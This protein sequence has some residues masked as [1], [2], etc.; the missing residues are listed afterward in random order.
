MVEELNDDCQLH[1]I[2]YL[3]LPDQL[4]L[5]RATKNAS[6]RWNNNIC[7]AWR[8]QVCYSL[9]S[10]VFEEFDNDPA[11]LDAFL[12]SICNT[13][14]SVEFKYVTL[15]HLKRWC[16]YKF[17]NMRD[18]KYTLDDDERSFQT[19]LELLVEMFPA[20]KSLKPYGDINC[21]KIEQFK[22]LR[23]LDL[24]ECKIYDLEGSENLEELVLEL[25]FIEDIFQSDD[26]MS[27]PRLQT[28]SYQCRAEYEKLLVKA[29]K[30]RC[31]D[32][33]ELSF[34]DCIWAYDLTT[35]QSP[36]CLS[37][38]SLIED[39]GLQ[40]EQ[41]QTLVA[42]LPLL[43]QLDLVDFQFYS[44]E[45]QLWKTVAVCPS[46]EILN[47]SG[48]QLYEDFFVLNRR[49]MDQALRNRSVPL[50]LHCHNTGANG[51]LV[52]YTVFQI[53]NVFYIVFNNLQIKTHFRHSNLKI[54]FRPLPIR[55]VYPG[56]TC[57]QLQPLRSS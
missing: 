8:H 42:G 32:I 31:N 5:W 39:D 53:N 12:S 56:Y 43:K 6:V 15:D 35:L 36:K 29:V 54:S 41:L 48:M 24:T 10:I 20:L 9:D 45:I 13:L 47:I 38:L 49:Y 11:L 14:Q 22:H 3:D 51:H 17:P 34:H 46:L 40:V 57:I 19:I 18:L 25:F 52:S 27:L 30:E 44:N 37:K 21:L 1:I 50:T 33:I 55:S 23:K 16:K 4:R 26:L 28:L 7:Q 2:Y